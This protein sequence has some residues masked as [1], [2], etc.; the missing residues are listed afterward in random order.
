VDNWE[1]TN[2]FKTSC[3]RCEGSV[4]PDAFPNESRK[5]YA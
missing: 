5:E 1:Y 4:S 2:Q 3:E